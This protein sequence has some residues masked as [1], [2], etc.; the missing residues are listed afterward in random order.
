MTHTITIT[1]ESDRPRDELVSAVNDVILDL[2]GG[3]IGDADSE[4]LYGATLVSVS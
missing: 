3:Y 1:I 2:A 4:P